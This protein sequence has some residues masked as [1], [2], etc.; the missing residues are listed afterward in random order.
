MNI[1]M[2]KMS[3]NLTA[4]VLRTNFKENIHSLISNDKNLY[5]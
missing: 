3:E 4:G 1:A 5:L 2:K